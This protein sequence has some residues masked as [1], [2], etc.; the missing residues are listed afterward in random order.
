M[1]EETLEGHRALLQ[2][3]HVARLHADTEPEHALLLPRM[4][5]TPALPWTVLSLNA[6]GQEKQHC[7]Q[8]PFQAALPYGQ[9]SLSMIG[10]WFC[11]LR[12]PASVRRGPSP[13]SGDALL[14]SGPHS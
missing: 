7:Y 13:G 4:L 3:W 10:Q 5:S 11:I 9:V 2:G 8:Q 12:V 6:S 1:P 14:S